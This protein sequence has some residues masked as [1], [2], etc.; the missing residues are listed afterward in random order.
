MAVARE[1]FSLMQQQPTATSTSTPASSLLYQGLLTDIL[2]SWNTLIGHFWPPQ[3]NRMVKRLLG[4]FVVGASISHEVAGAPQCVASNASGI[5]LAWYAPNATAVNDLGKVVN[6]TG[7]YG[8]IFNSSVTPATSGYGTYNWCN[9]PHVRPQ[10][11]VVPSRE[12]KLEYVEV[13]RTF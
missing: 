9:M 1:V 7:V 4:L 13:V 3:D 12:F 5:D 8:F 11:Y 6:G 2:T 10:E